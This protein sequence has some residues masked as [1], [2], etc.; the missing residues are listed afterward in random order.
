MKTEM[1]ERCSSWIWHSKL[2]ID[3]LDIRILG[4]IVGVHSTEQFVGIKFG[5]FDPGIRKSHQ[6][7]LSAG[8]IFCYGDE[9]QVV[10]FIS[11]LL[12]Y[13]SEVYA[14]ETDHE[15]CFRSCLIL[16]FISLLCN[17][18]LAAEA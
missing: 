6:H 7:R 5:A 2:S 9:E 12:Q 18:I 8:G 14:Y 3:S 17:V 1:Q 13:C 4:R 10:F 16:T 11:H 15:G